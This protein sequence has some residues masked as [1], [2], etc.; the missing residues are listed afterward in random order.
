MFIISNP[1]KILTSLICIASM[2][3]FVISRKLSNDNKNEIFDIDDIINDDSVI[4][5]KIEAPVVIKKIN[6]SMVLFLDG[7]PF[8]KDIHLRLLANKYSAIIQKYVEEDPKAHLHVTLKFVTSYFD[9]KL[10]DIS[11]KSKLDT[12]IDNCRS[13]SIEAKGLTGFSES[14]RLY[15]LLSVIQTR[16]AVMKNKRYEFSSTS[17]AITNQQIIIDRIHAVFNRVNKGF[18]TKYPTF[19]TNYSILTRKIKSITVTKNDIF[20]LDDFDSFKEKEE[21]TKAPAKKKKKIASKKLSTDI[22]SKKEKI[23][24]NLSTPPELTEDKNLP[25]KPLDN[26][27]L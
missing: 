5:K 18:N 24:E 20:I 14:R 7:K 22:P 19:I 4:T 25:I 26:S 17:S 15:N 10:I 8:E 11:H 2:K 9:K 6:V 27:S 3:R 13:L 23:V 1:N 12:F 16:L 21:S